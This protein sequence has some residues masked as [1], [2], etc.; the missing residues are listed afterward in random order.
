MAQVDQEIAANQLVKLFKYLIEH[1]DS[2][3]KSACEELGINYRAALRW[4]NDGVLH[5]YLSEI[6]DVRSDLA[7]ILALD[8]LPS[9]VKYQAR[10]ARGEISPN[11]ASPTGAATFVLN[12]AKL[13]ARRELTNLHMSQIGLFVPEMPKPG[14]SMIDAPGKLVEKED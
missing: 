10:I 11:G 14:T 1:P 13:G 12:V 2:N 7:Q 9:V 8:E 5:T 3:K 6:H 4:I